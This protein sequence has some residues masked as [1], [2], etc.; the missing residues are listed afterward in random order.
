MDY[1]IAGLYSYEN[2]L[3]LSS[4]SFIIL[5]FFFWDSCRKYQTAGLLQFLR[6][7]RL[8]HPKHWRS[9]SCYHLFKSEKDKNYE[10]ALIHQDFTWKYISVLKSWNSEL[11]TE[12]VMKNTKKVPELKNPIILTNYRLLFS[13]YLLRITLP[14]I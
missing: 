2:H 14:L 5:F 1:S 13:I 11:Q 6:D 8:K 12:P 7:R 3:R 4:D 10:M 9:K